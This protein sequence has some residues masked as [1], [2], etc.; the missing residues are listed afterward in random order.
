MMSKSK[1]PCRPPP[2]IRRILEGAI[3]LERRINNRAVVFRYPR[4][5]DLD[6]F[7]RMRLAFHKEQIMADA[8]FVDPPLAA[9]RLADIM[10]GMARSR[11][12][13]LFVLLDGR[14][15]GQGSVGQSAPLYCT[16]GLAI[17][18]CARGLG[19]GR[20]MMELLERDALALGRR[21]LFLTV[22][23]ANTVAY[24]LYRKLGY[25]EVGSRE[26]WWEIPGLAARAGRRLTDLVEMEKRLD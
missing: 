2:G 4:W 1:Q 17:M 26:E 5:S 22:Y 25:R 13:W 14:L 23:R 16:I 18:K 24:E 21:R 7:Y 6:E 20:L 8:S 3:V 10:V 19:L 11:A 12:R 15:V 9:Q